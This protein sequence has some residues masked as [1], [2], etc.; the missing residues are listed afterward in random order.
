MSVEGRMPQ[1]PLARYGVLLGVTLLAGGIA[2]GVAGVV[3]V[4]PGA[5]GPVGA[6][7]IGAATALAMGL[8]LWASLRWW[9]GLDEAAH[10]AHKWAWWWGSTFGLAAAGVTLLSLVHGAPA[11]LTG[12]PAEM[13]LAGAALVALFQTAGYAV[14]WSVWWLRRR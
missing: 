3:A 9:R 4:T 8:G 7:V 2:G 13:F 6:S 10:E 12:A 5:P 14:A 1:H 11:V